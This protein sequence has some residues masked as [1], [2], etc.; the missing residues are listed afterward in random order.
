MYA[1]YIIATCKLNITKVIPLFQKGGSN[2]LNNYRPF[3]LLPSVTKVLQ[4]ACDSDTNCR[5]PPYSSACLVAGYINSVQNAM[6]IGAKA[7]HEDNMGFFEGFID[8]V[9][10]RRRRFRKQFTLISLELGMFDL[11]I[12]E[13]NVG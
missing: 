6:I 8:D 9:S 3:S 13:I 2:Q 10:I 1:A 4:K 11:E 5:S 12:H 7:C